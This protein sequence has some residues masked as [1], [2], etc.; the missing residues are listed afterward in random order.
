M[1]LADCGG[2]GLGDSVQSPEEKSR[3]RWV[4]AENFVAAI[5][6]DKHLMKA[7]RRQLKS[8]LQDARYESA[9]TPALIKLF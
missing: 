9:T 7:A 3:Q 2:A 5:K 1:T 6:G 8:L 4:A